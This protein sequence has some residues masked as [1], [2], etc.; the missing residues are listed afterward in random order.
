MLDRHSRTALVALTLISS[1]LIL[2]RS[3]PLWLS[4]GGAIVGFSLSLIVREADGTKKSRQ[5]GKTF[6]LFAISC[7][8]SLSVLEIGARKFISSGGT[9]NPLFEPNPEYLFRLKPNAEARRRIV[10]NFGK[11]RWVDFKISSQGLRDR[12][13]G[14]KEPGEF[15]IALLGDS[16]TMGTAVDMDETLSRLLEKNLKAN[17]QFA[18]VTVI[19]LGTGGTG[20]WQQAGI[21]RD[22]GFP[23]QPDLVIQQLFLGNDLG[24]TL[25]HY[26]KTPRAYTP[27]WHDRVRQFQ[28]MR[29]VQYRVDR[30]LEIHSRG[31]YALREAV[32][33]ANFQR[34]VLDNLRFLPVPEEPELPPSLTRPAHL[35]Q[36]LAKSYPDL[37]FAWDQ[38]LMDLHKIAEDCAARHI[39]Y[40]VFCIPT[41]EEISPKQ[42]AATTTTVRDASR[43]A[44]GKGL[45]DLY[46][47]LRAESFQT[48]SVADALYSQ[49]D[50]DSLYYRA[51]GHL[52][53][54][55]N[56]I[57]AKRIGEFCASWSTR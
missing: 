54:A 9:D 36:D 51:D 4:L 1:L 16:F 43:Y 52:T 35:E 3:I 40:A 13:Y 6:F 22:R 25:A 24:D 41:H 20:P 27:A 47:R 46:S 44:R 11:K 21:L 50:P 17:P 12:E 18:N 48:F 53:P 23:L 5:R 39:G 56:A 15:R 37:D 7:V 26:G 38:L 55:G 32:G 19:N 10:L 28:H 29:Y 31:Y 57:V 2:F 30:W 14:P 8:M 42:W 49:P 33:L 34:Y 45:R